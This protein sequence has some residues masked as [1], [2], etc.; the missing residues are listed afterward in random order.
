MTAWVGEKLGVDVPVHFTAFHPDWKMRDVPATPRETLTRARAIALENGLRY[1]Y[2]GNV[3]D[4]EGSSTW[5]HACGALLIERDWYVL[6]HWG[7]DA[8]SRCAGC[9][10]PLPGHFEAQPGKFGAR[11]IPISINR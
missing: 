4:S 1:V 10:E 2:T 7:L 11:R 6:G 9:G 5:C 8:D 3:H